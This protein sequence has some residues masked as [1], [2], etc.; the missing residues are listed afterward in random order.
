MATRIHSLDTA[1]LSSFNVSSDCFYVV[2]NGQ[3]YALSAGDL[4]RVVG[5]PVGVRAWVPSGYA[6][7]SN[8]TW[9]F[10]NV[11]WDD[12]GWTTASS[13]ALFTVPAGVNWIDIKLHMR[14]FALG[15]NLN[16]VYV[17]GSLTT[18]WFVTH[19]NADSIYPRAV[20]GPV[21][22]NSGDVL[23]VVPVTG[24]QTWYLSSNSGVFSSIEI[25]VLGYSQ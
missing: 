20:S 4:G 18:S 3:D 1:P 12:G 10:E 2:W 11:D 24:T 19:K 5:R 21:R 13:K 9:D 7:Y 8:S 15:N 25:E 16:R 23:T 6:T 14:S 17:N 22:V